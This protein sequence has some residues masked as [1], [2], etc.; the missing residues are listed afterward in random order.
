MSTVFANMDSQVQGVQFGLQTYV[1]TVS[2]P[3]TGILDTIVQCMVDCRIGECEAYGPVLEPGDL[4]D[5][6]RS[7]TATAEERAQARADLAKWRASVP[8]AYYEGI[9]KKF[10][11][12]GVDIWAYTANFGQTDE[13]IERALAQAKALGAKVISTGMGMAAARRV[14]PF[15][16]KH[17]LLIGLQGVPN[18]NGANPDQIRH[19]EQFL[20]AV[21]L[22]KQ[23]RL[24]FDIGDATGGGW[25]AL[26]FVR[27]HPEIIAM[28]YVKDR[29]KDNTSVPYGEGD[30]PVKQILQL[31][32]DKKYPI[33]AY[34]DCDY[35]TEGTRSDAVK[36]SYEYAKAALA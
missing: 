13:D 36:R 17:G 2:G 31:I 23:F 14:A 29:K 16:E 15:A 26:Q 5:R 21:A 28:I 1:F 34:I 10:N 32:R 24:C 18:G 35:R 4:S 12:A 3:R 7:Q 33:R 30:T 9:R 20:E 25:D 8:L 27:D 19:P 6:A 22:S 11:D